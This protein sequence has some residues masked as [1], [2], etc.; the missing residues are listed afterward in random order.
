VNEEQIGQLLA[1][2]D[3]TAGDPTF[4][5]IATAGI[6]RR[7]HHRRLVRV[8]A[9]VSLAAVVAIS[10]ALSAIFVPAEG[11]QAPPQ[12]IA[13]LEEQVRQLQ[14]RTD[15]TLK[16][17]QEV[18]EKDRQDRRLAALET[19]LASIPDPLQEIDRQ[20]DRTAF[21]LVYQADKLYK[22]LNQ[23]ESAVA[24]YKEVIQLFPTN[25]WAAVARERLSQ[26]EQPRLNKSDRE[27]GEPK[28]QPRNT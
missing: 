11:P 23:R 26:I 7:V 6:R 24:A 9:P 12:R 10:V 4:R 13:S 5:P 18:L 1:K 2:A 8:A 19:E 16:L 22:E 25:R 20:V 21:I 17:V 15:A 28:W 14:A 3:E 27:K